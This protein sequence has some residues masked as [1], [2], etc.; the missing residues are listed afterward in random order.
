[1]ILAVG[2]RPRIDFVEYI[3][4]TFPD[5]RVVG[6]AVRGG[7]II[8]ATQDAYAQAFVFEP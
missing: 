6:D 7:R 3:E 5:G 2:V 1:M 4:A 8:D